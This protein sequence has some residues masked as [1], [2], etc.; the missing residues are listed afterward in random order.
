MGPQATPFKTTTS[1]ARSIA[2]PY[3]LYFLYLDPIMALGGVYLIFTDPNKFMKSTVPN[4][5]SLDHTPITPLLT[6][7][8]TNIAALYAYLAINEAL[9]LRV[10]T[11]LAVWKVVIA[12]LVVTDVG[13]VYGV[14]AASPE[15][16]R[17]AELG[18]YTME[19]MVNLGILL[20]GLGLRLAFLA[21]IRNRK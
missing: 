15:R 10:T 19:E 12:A 18:S 16:M 11:Q 7:L 9:I 17:F 14:W 3:R 2:L 1:L 20:F 21:G 6:L 13:H 8:L 4:T 5:L